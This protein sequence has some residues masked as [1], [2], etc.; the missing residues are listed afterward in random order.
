ML[1]NLTIQNFRGLSDLSL[2]GLGR[3][4]VLLGANNA[5]KTS[6][7]EAV[8]MLPELGGNIVSTTDL[9]R[10]FMA[11]STQQS[12]YC[13]YSLDIERKINISADTFLGGTRKLCILSAHKAESRLFAAPGF[14]KRLPKSGVRLPNGYKLRKLHCDLQVRSP[15]GQSAGIG[16]N[17]VINNM[18]ESEPDDIEG[19]YRAYSIEIA[20]EPFTAA[21]SVPGSRGEVDALNSVIGNKRKSHLLK[22]VQRVEPR[23]VDCAVIGSE[24]YLDIG[25]S[26]LIPI[27]MFGD[28]I[29]SI[30]GILSLVYAG[31]NQI[32]LVDQIEDG[33]HF[34][35]VRPL[36]EALIAASRDDDIQFFIATHD[37]EV[38]QAIRE[39][40]ES[41]KFSDFQPEIRCYHLGRDKEGAIRSYRYDYEQFE[42][43]IGSAIEIR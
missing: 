42:H 11:D 29:K 26:G 27:N 8:H 39:I 16:F 31:E 14:D 9:V 32:M 17:F 25:I 18:G 36:L 38:L 13:F 30:F 24:I 28:G 35:A 6:V 37:L 10:N 3:F 4:N 21:Y 41:D 7:L 40:T 34:K 23:I 15:N 20:R 5:G 12:I 19:D 43:C 1:K 22:A 33:L 2:E